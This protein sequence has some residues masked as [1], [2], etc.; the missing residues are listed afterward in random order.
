MTGYFL[1]F[2]NHLPT[3]RHEYLVDVAGG[4]CRRFHEKQAVVFCIRLSLLQTIR[5]HD[6]TDNKTTEDTNILF[7]EKE[8]NVLYNE[9]LYSPHMEDNNKK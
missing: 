6:K 4:F 5:Q 8:H 9:N 2:R 1:H 3:Y 7:A